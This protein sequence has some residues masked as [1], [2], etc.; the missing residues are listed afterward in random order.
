MNRTFLA[1]LL[2]LL[3]AL[4][5]QA[6]IAVGEWRAHMAYHDATRCLKLDDKVFV[7]SSGSLFAYYPE[8]SFVDIYNKAT[9]L[10]DVNISYMLK[11]NDEN[12]L[13]LVYDNAN[14]D[15]LKAD[16]SLYNISDFFQKSTYDP[17]INDVSI[18]G[19]Y[20]YLATNFGIVV[21]NLKKKEFTNTYPST[22]KIIS[23]TGNG[24]QII[25]ATTKGI[26]G[27]MTSK[28]LL[29]PESW[30]LLNDIYFTQ[31]ITYANT[32]IGIRPS[33]GIFTI[34]ETGKLK[35]ILE[36]NTFKWMRVSDGKLYISDGKSIYIFDES[37]T[38]PSFFSIDENTSDFILSGNTCWMAC[39][40]EGLK[41]FSVGNDGTLTPSVS[42]IIP[43][44]PMRNKCDYLSFT[45]NEKLLVAGGALNY[46]DIVF[47]KG[48]VETFED[49][50][51]TIFEEENLVDKSVM[52]RGYCDATSV[53][54]DP[55]DEAHHFV[56]SYGQG[57]YEFRNGKFIK[58]LNSENSPLE[59]AVPGVPFYTRVSRLQ[60]DKEGNLWITN[61]HATSPIKVMK[62]D[63]TFVDVYY[64]E[65][66]NQPTVTDILFDSNGLTWVIVMRADAGLFCIDNNKTPFNTADDK[67]RFISPSFRDQDGNLTTIDYICDIA[68]DK[69]GTI[70]VLTNQGPFVIYNPEEY[71][72]P[73]F[74][75]TKI[76]VPR[77]DGTNFAD[78]LLDAVYCTCIAIDDANR[79]WIGTQSSGIYL[80]SADGLETIHHFT[81]ENSPLLSNSIKDI[82]I[83]R[84]TGEVFIGT[85]KGLVSFRS[86]A[87]IP[88]E[89]FEKET[90]YAFPNPVSADYTGPISI[91]GLM[92]NS[93]VKILSTSGKLVAEGT[94]QGG[95][96]TWY[97]CY[98]SGERVPTGVY[99]VLATSEDGKEGIDTRIVIIR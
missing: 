93:I 64:K 6:Q 20:A 24:S 82:A 58:N 81:T 30:T 87:T 89:S 74:T 51:W 98:S 47:T 57:I 91:V 49:E 19:S 79:K 80:I 2:I 76:K 40:S 60:Y 27:G 65:L 70:W 84:S 94:S 1:T 63:G 12:L 44:S 42:S 83:K 17:T 39:G 85:E 48:T 33:K 18:S 68:E 88:A 14:I 66:E 10:S 56:S 43:D 4:S 38:N 59:T 9:G 45:D 22:E 35:S 97:G 34:S 37:L 8:D 15:L 26:L 99:H 13:M 72:N 73:N 53:A 11:C 71:F 36:G 3:G 92:D 21:V 77:N 78:Y 41:G 5:L 69:E 16:G 75:F 46:F 86:D 62:K 28:N 32:F 31:L 25:A 96:F 90:I 7:L 61:S 67:T 23:C 95:S 54:Q 29:D 55:L 50:T 52:K